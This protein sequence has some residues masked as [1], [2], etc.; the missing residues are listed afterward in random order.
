MVSDKIRRGSILFA[1][2]MIAA[3]A[4]PVQAQPAEHVSATV[5][6]KNQLVQP[7]E[8][9]RLLE[10]PAAGMPLVFQVGSRTLFDEG[11]IPGAKYAGPASTKA[12]LDSLR[13]QVAALPRGRAIVL[14]CGCCPWDHCPNIAPAWELLHS[15]GFTNVRALYLANDFGTDW[16]NRGYHVETAP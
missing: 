8:L 14:Y 4:L 3:A 6:P 10:G 13:G 16:V 15:M 1:A 11:H 7:V 12:G 5:I 9:A 2:L